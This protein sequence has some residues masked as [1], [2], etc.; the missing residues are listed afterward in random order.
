MPQ[1]F[2][3]KKRVRRSLLDQQSKR[4]TKVLHSYHDM[5]LKTLYGTV[6]T[7]LRLGRQDDEFTGRKRDVLGGKVKPTV[8]QSMIDNVTINYPFSNL[9]LFGDLDTKAQNQIGSFDI[10]E[11]LPI[12][13]LVPFK[14]DIDVDPVELKQ[15]DLIVDC[16]FDHNGNKIPLVL[17]IKRLRGGMHG[18]HLASKKYEVSIFRGNLTKEM[19]KR[20]DE[21]VDKIAKIQ[22]GEQP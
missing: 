19:Q 18:K 2:S 13:M 15:D 9:E 21:F 3:P 7:I 14:G 17:Q 16:F 5:Q 6:T 12:T 11:F 20:V 1:P 10:T 8:E 22:N 4:L